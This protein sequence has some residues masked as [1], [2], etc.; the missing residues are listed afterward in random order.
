MQSKATLYESICDE[1]KIL[2]IGKQKDSRL[3]KKSRPIL[4]MSQSR[5]VRYGFFTKW[6]LNQIPLFNVISLIEIE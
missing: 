5:V 2:R 1:C 6:T 4:S 3:D